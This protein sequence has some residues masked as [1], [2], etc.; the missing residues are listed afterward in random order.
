M[1]TARITQHSRYIPNDT[2][3]FNL[4]FVLDSNYMTPILSK[5]MNIDTSSHFSIERVK[6]KP[7]KNCLICYRQNNKDSSSNLI[8]ITAMVYPPGESQKRFEKANLA[9]FETNAVQHI[10]H[11]DMVIW[12]FP[13]ER[14]LIHLPKLFDLDYLNSQVFPDLI[15]KAKGTEWRLSDSEIQLVHYVPEHNCTVRADLTL[16]NKHSGRITDLTVYG[17][18]YYNDQGTHTFH[19]M[20]Q[21]YSKNNSSLSAN[22]LLYQESYKTLWQE[23]VPGT[24]LEISL[25]SNYCYQNLKHAA[26]AILQL[27]QTTVNCSTIIDETYFINQLNRTE[28]ALSTSSTDYLA[29]FIRIKDSL[30]KNIPKH[31]FENLNTLH[32]DLHPNNILI[33]DNSVYLIDLDSTC[34]GPAYA[35]IG[36]WCAAIL[37]QALLKKHGLSNANKK[38]SY[39]LQNYFKGSSLVEDQAA[40]K[41]FTTMALINERIFRCATRLKIGRNNTFFELLKL[42]QKTCQNFQ[43]NYLSSVT[44]S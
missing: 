17:K 10:P 41:W 31:C 6:Y 20:E 25:N 28:A 22:P 7:K 35:D 4:E 3:L 15:T 5:Y 11:L 13:Y 37:Y 39:F 42:A 12:K 38:L 2:R 44:A 9:I 23:A 24:P 30:L 43:K 26:N 1:S 21:I 40:L 16:R 36:S 8:D 32:G 27:H 19:T 34:L 14:K 18:T 33:S 29:Q